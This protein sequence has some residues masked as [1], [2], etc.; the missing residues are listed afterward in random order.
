[1]KSVVF[2]SFF[3]LPSFASASLWS[4]SN[5]ED[6]TGLRG[7]QTPTPVTILKC[8]VVV[9]DTEFDSGNVG[10]F[11]CLP[12]VNDVVTEM[13]YPL[14]LPSY[15]LDENE[16]KLLV[17]NREI[18]IHGGQISND[19]DGVSIPDNAIIQLLRESRVVF[20]VQEYVV[21]KLLIVRVLTTDSRPSLS[22]AEL[23]EQTFSNRTMTLRSQF[24]ACS[25]GKLLFDPL[26]DDSKTGIVGGVLS[27]QLRI[28]V[29]RSRRALTNA[30]VAATHAA[31]G[32]NMS[33]VADN[34][35]FCHPPGSVGD[36]LAYAYLNGQISA[37]NDK[38]CGYISATMHE[39]GHNLGFRHSNQNGE[40]ADET[41]YM[42]NSYKI[43]GYPSMCFNAHKNWISGWFLDRIVTVDPADGIWKGYLATF[44]D[45][46]LTSPGEYVVIKV[47]DLYMQYN[48]AKGM[49]FETREMRDQMTIAR[50][51]QKGSELIAG[52]DG[53]RTNST[54]YFHNNYGENNETLYIAVCGIELGDDLTT[55]DRM[56]ISV[57][58]NNLDCSPPAWI[59][60][61]RGQLCDDDMDGTFFVDTDLENQGC[62]WLQ[63]Q[64]L[65]QPKLCVPGSGAY[66]MC[67][68]TCGKCIDSCVDDNA[69]FDYNGERVDCTELRGRTDL[70]WEEMC[71]VDGP[72]QHCR[73]TCNS[74]PSAID[75]ASKCDDSQDY[76]VNV[77]GFD[78]TCA[79]LS[80]PAQTYFR[81]LFCAENEIFHKCAETCGKCFDTCEDDATAFITWDEGQRTCQYLSERPNEWDDAC[82]SQLHIR[83]SCRETCETCR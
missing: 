14:E 52:L 80:Q 58:L 48:R 16:S 65:E 40:Y 55:P 24:K 35:I 74:C 83:E 79:W 45:Y 66:D 25:H 6:N 23:S 13:S 36:W 3:L 76:A 54:L 17:G 43:Q 27:V 4:N 9:V 34:I 51:G 50:E 33:D 22:A 20:D 47:G 10:G 21:R 78:L 8:K 41:G 42:G 19:D 44:V 82:S 7:L 59:E 72:F 2:T 69:F 46:D 81:P 62:R 37:F 1:M 31:L 73:E 12:M 70:E 38:S 56:W 49:N 53:L 57:G 15:F 32:G 61:N 28:T 64:P 26:P 63:E 18:L 68:E 67:P 11:M 30:A 5:H 60:P 77:W 75:K 71:E 29:G 39:V